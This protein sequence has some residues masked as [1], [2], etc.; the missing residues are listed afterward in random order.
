M[1]WN[2]LDLKDG[3]HERDSNLIDGLTFDTLLLEIHCNIKDINVHTVRH[4]FDE[5]LQGRI[6]EA[7]TIFETNLLNIVK[8]AKKERARK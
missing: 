7:R 4:Q 6:D 8:Q 1:N 5:D 2:N 3:S